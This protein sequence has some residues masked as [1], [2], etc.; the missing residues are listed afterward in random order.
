MRSVRPTIFS[1]RSIALASS[2]SNIFNPTGHTVHAIDQ[3]I[4]GQ[5]CR[6]HCYTV[7]L[8]LDESVGGVRDGSIA[9]VADLCICDRVFRDRIFHAG[10]LSSRRCRRST[11]HSV[12]KVFIHRLSYPVIIQQIAFS[13]L[14]NERASA[15]ATCIIL[16]S[17]RTRVTYIRQTNINVSIL[18]S[19]VVLLT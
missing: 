13:G 17:S 15:A 16:R 6:S 10:F 4:A 5:G 7:G 12:L 1:L 11:L 8:P 19:R 3:S 2:V 9:N 18:P 14:I